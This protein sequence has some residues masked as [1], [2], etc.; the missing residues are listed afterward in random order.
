MYAAT[1]YAGAPYAGYHAPVT[2]TS[3][4]TIKGDIVYITT[5]DAEVFVMVDDYQAIEDTVV[6]TTYLDNNSQMVILG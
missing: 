2:V 1:P 3:T 6:T 5:A 4:N